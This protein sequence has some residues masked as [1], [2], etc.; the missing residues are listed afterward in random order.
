NARNGHIV[1]SEGVIKI[2]NSKYTDD[3]SPLDPTCDCYTC[4]NF[5]KSYLHHLD[6]TKEIRGSRLITI[7]NLTFYQNLMKSLR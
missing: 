5:T 6:K 2:R 4:K 1:S 7:H 3:T